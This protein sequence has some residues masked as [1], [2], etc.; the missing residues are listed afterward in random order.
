MPCSYRRLPATIYGL[1]NAIR[2]EQNVVFG[3]LYYVT[4]WT[5]G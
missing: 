5:F 4:D 3:R 1:L 2:R